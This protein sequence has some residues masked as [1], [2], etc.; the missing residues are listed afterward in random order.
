MIALKI[1][2]LKQFMN[3][4]LCSGLFDR[5][6]LAEATIQK[7]ASF[8][9]DGHINPAFYSEDERNEQGLSDSG[10][11][12]F[13]KLRPFCHQLMR[14]SRAPLS[15]Q[16]IFMLSPKHM[17]QTLA[18]S[19]SGFTPN[20]ISGIFLNLSFQNQTLLLTTGISYS[21]FAANHELDREWDQMAKIF[22]QKNG[23]AFEEM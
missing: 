5:F 11:L 6:L 10:I 3:R 17:A 20:D 18:R 12:P 19:A 4:L 21:T 13:S 1:T 2:E 23:I 22:L 14:G 7:D 16:F 15:F 9:I 8:T